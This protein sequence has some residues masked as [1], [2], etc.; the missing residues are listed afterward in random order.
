MFSSPARSEASVKI[1]RHYAHGPETVSSEQPVKVTRHHIGDGSP[2]EGVRRRTVQNTSH[3]LPNGEEGQVVPGWQPAK[4]TNDNE[5]NKNWNNSTWEWVPHN[6]S[7]STLINGW[8]GSE[9]VAP[10][11]VSVDTGAGEQHHE[12]LIELKT[13]N[14]TRNFLDPD[15][16]EVLHLS[17]WKSTHDNDPEEENSW[18]KQGRK[19]T[20]RRAIANM[21]VGSAS[22]TSG[23]AVGD[24]MISKLEVKDPPPQHAGDSLAGLVT[25]ER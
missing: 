13:S 19:G 10:S 6:S 14:A 18:L 3:H 9:G 1:T 11:K 7:A 25:N 15:T 4:N 16:G 21:S 2:F 12:G 17:P 5:V 8:T 22:L 20:I 23:K 24:V